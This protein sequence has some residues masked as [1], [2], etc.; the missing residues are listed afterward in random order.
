[1]MMPGLPTV[2]ELAYGAIIGTVE[3]VDCVPY[4]TVK[5]RPFAEPLGWC[6]VLENPRPVEPI[7]MAGRL[8]LFEIEL[9]TVLIDGN[10]VA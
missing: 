3:V 1:M 7:P 4:E 9:S 5:D 2:D 10:L 6:W 8:G